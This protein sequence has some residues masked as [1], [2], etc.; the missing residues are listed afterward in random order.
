M[1]AAITLRIGSRGSDLALWQAREVQSRLQEQFPG[2]HFPIEVIKTLGDRIQDRA[3][4]RVE[5][6]GFF[7]KEIEEALLRKRCDLAVHSLKDLPV[8]SPPDLMV[9][10][11]PEREDPHDVWISRRGGSIAQAAPGTVVGTSALRRQ[12]QLK[13]VRDDLS[14]RDLRG[15]VPTRLRRLEEGEID[16]LVLARAGLYRL[17]LLPAQAVAIPFEQMLPAPGQGALAIQIRAGDA[18]ARTCV[19]QLDHATTR[20]TV[21]AER[22]FLRRLQGGCLLPV[23]AFAEI[24]GGRLVLQGMVADLSGSPLFRAKDEC[25]LEGAGE[26][27]A[28]DL[29]TRMAAR[30]LAEGAAPVLERVREFLLGSQGGPDG[31]ART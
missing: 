26:Q 13:A 2:G 16:A 31:G 19:A 29:G 1:S 21:S 9:A 15:N 12:A 22:A 20:I 14:Y 11:I 8:Q 6:K 24:S 27:S 5:D 30:L 23:G 28:V 17:G 4:Y 18:Q 10:A 7:T 3:L 25:L